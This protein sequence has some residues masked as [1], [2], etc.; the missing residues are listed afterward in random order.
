MICRVCAA[1]YTRYTVLYTIHIYLLHPEVAAQEHEG[2]RADRRRVAHHEI[3]RR[4]RHLTCT[5]IENIHTGD[6]INQTAAVAVFT[7]W[8]SLDELVDSP[9]HTTY[10]LSDIFTPRNFS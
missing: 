2:Q 5:H 6:R 8:A 3:A 1:F 4:P 7:A 9:H 10:L